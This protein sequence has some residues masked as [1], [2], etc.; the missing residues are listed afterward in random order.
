MD[1]LECRP[2][3]LQYKPSPQVST[4]ASSISSIIFCE[5]SWFREKSRHQT[6]NMSVVAILILDH[7]L[8]RPF[9]MAD[10]VKQIGWFARTSSSSANF[11][12]RSLH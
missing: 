2:Q 4:T 11:F 7:Y 1:G 9:M 12:N 5:Q 10:R 6:S 8:V 3:T